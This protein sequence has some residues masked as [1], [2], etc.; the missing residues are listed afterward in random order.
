MTLAP[1]APP[2]RFWLETT[3]P[4]EAVAFFGSAVHTIVRSSAIAGGSPME[5]RRADAGL[6]SLDEVGLPLEYTFRI[7][8]VGRLN[9]SHRIQGT[10]ERHTPRSQRAVRTRRSVHRRSA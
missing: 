6:F 7:E 5:Y 10:G 1:I 2:Q 9:I 8:A 4:E 3:D